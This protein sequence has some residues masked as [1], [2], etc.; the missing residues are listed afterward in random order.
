MDSYFSYELY[1]EMQREETSASYD[2]DLI[3]RA[4]EK[5]FSE[6]FE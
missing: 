5:A 3:E 4:Y 2:N 1:L 6:S